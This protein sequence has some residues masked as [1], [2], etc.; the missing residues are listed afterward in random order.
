MLRAHR[1]PDRFLSTAPLMTDHFCKAFRIEPSRCW[2]FGY[3]RSDDAF[4][5]RERLRARLA[6]KDPKS[7]AIL[8]RFESFERVVLYMPTYRDSHRDVLLD[9]GFDFDRL[10]REMAARNTLFVVKLHP[11][12]RSTFPEPGRHPNLWFASNTD[13][14]YPVMPFTDVL[15]TDYSSVYFDYLLLGKPVALVVFDEAQ[16]MREDRDLVLDFDTHS[17]GPR[18]RSFDELLALFS[19]DT[20][21]LDPAQVAMRR[22]FWGDYAGGATK[23][24]ADALVQLAKGCRAAGTRSGGTGPV[25]VVC[26]RTPIGPSPHRRRRRRR[27]ARP[28]RLA[29]PRRRVVLP[30]ADV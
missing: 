22:L 27:R 14:L 2:E 11:W 10:D 30:S 26:G 18:A 9:A 5:P 1:A 16:Y 12:S 3:P 4:L 20:V 28:R 17:P 15:V 13:D 24:V 21:P 19:V 23:A 8:Q 29:R 6:E 7:F 25:A